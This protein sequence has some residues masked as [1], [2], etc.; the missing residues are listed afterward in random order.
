RDPRFTQGTCRA[1]GGKQLHAARGK[2]ATEVDQ[3]A[4]VGNAEEGATHRYGGGAGHGQVLDQAVQ[5]QLLV[6]GGAVDAEHVGGTA[7]VAV[8]E[9]HGLAQHGDLEFTQY[10]GV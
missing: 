8:V 3:A 7:L 2:P 9:G 10:Q 4:F 1:A 6:Q 5:G